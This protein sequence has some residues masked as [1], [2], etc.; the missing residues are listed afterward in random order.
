MNLV[1]EFAKLL[2]P[3]SKMTF[4]QRKVNFHRDLRSILNWTMYN[5]IEQAT[6]ETPI[7]ETIA[8]LDMQD[9]LV[10]IGSYYDMIPNKVLFKYMLQMLVQCING[11]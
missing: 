8:Q 9:R 11:I 2:Q 6:R 1:P 10:F 3:P 7:A 5:V 4:L